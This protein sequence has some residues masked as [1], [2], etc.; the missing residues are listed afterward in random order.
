MSAEAVTIIIPA[1][2]GY[3]SRE[4][5]GELV[6][7][8]LAIT[9]DINGNGTARNSRYRLTHVAS[10]RTI[11]TA[12]CRTHAEAAAQLA[13]TAP[14][15]DWANE[16][17]KAIAAAPDLR[18]FSAKLVEGGLAKPCG[19]RCDPEVPAEQRYDVR[20]NTCDWRYSEDDDDPITDPKEAKQVARDH[21]CEPC[22]EIQRPGMDQW[23]WPVELLDDDGSVHLPPVV[24]AALGV[25]QSRPREAS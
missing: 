14:G 6:A 11:G 8:G 7:P 2:D 17:H 1:H 24:Y 5:V 19:R 18:A 20:C 22:V 15:I 3:S 4:V 25:G 9:P 10:G 13:K 12:W 21:E 23:I 16:D